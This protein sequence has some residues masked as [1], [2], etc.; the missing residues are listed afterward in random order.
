M[1]T[2]RRFLGY[3][4]LTPALMA[5]RPL[6][7]SAMAQP[8][9]DPSRPVIRLA[10]L[11]NEF[12]LGS[13]LQSITDHFLIG[14]QWEGAWHMPQVQVVSMYLEPAPAPVAGPAYGPGRVA[15]AEAAHNALSEGRA[16]E[17]GFRIY[18]NIPQALRCGGGELAVDAVLCVI[19]DGD[20]PRNRAGQVLYPRYDYFEQCVQVF[21]TDRRSVPIYNYGDLSFSAEQAKATIATAERMKFPIMAGSWMPAT[22]RIPDIDI[23]YGGAITEAVAVGIGDLGRDDFHALEAMQAMM[24]RRKGGETGVKSV[25]FL[26]GDAVWDAGEA[27]KWSKT[28]L[29]SAQSRSDAILGLTAMDGRPQNM[30]ASGVLPQLVRNPAAYCIEYTDGTRA[31]MLM[32]DGADNDFTFATEVPGHGRIATQFFRGPAPNLSYTAA[33]AHKI[34]Q[35]YTTKTAPFPVERTQLT[36]GILEACLTSRE[37]NNVRIETPHLAAIRYQAPQESQYART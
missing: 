28:L 23:P 20:Y 30:V 7:G 19:E 35:F 25:Q 13:L 29:S 34:E 15:P 3:S 5:Y 26:E 16:K 12:T 27:G 22:W 4:A 9:R 1:L 8:P 11:G 17:F 31:T 24:E 18:P 37:R 32:L 6:L 36:S 2:R 10:V 33:L 14:Y 21:Q